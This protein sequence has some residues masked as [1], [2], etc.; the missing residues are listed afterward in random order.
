MKTWE[1]VAI[2]AGIIAIAYFVMKDSDKGE[3][4]YQRKKKDDRSARFEP[5]SKTGS[6]S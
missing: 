2:G 5:W 4:E 3:Y 1:K 6:R